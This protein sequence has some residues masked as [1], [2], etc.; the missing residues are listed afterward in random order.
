MQAFF[1]RALATTGVTDLGQSTALKALIKRASLIAASI[2]AVAFD[3]AAQDTH[4]WTYQYGARANLL[5]GA[6]VGSVVDISAAYYNPGALSLVEDISLIATQKVF[7]L[8]SLTFDP[9]VGIDASLSDLRLD[10]AP[11]YFAGIIPF[12]FLGNDVLAYSLF[13]R[14]LFKSDV[15]A[16]A[17]GDLAEVT[18][19]LTGD[20]FKSTGFLRNLN[21][22]WVGVSYSSPF[23]DVMGLGLTAYVSYRSQKGTTGFLFESLNDSGESLMSI[24][25]RGFSYWNAAILFK[26][27]IAFDWLGASVGLTVTT[28]RINLFGEGKVL[29]NRSLF[30][31]EN[32]FVA[33]YQEGLSS[34]YKTPWSVALGAAYKRESTTVHITTEYFAPVS[35]FAV[36]SPEPFIGQST[37]DTIAAQLT[38]ELDDVLNFGLGLE[39]TFR[40][41]LSGYVSFRTD[42]SAAVEGSDETTDM[43]VTNWDIYFITAGAAFRI[44]DADLTAGLAFGWG[45]SKSQ[46]PE[47]PGLPSPSPKVAMKYRTLRLIIAFAI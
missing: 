13:T 38:Q 28:P 15:T 36:L 46:L 32:V 26:G 11:G 45:S 6:V 2:L 14:Y 43:G 30:N 19:S 25:D 34:T 40:P 44:G 23:Q 22:T 9:E 1:S 17:Q 42:F 41:H 21:E 10:L 24:R 39:H 20:F 33:D 4:Y 29:F 18:D 27:G 3:A 5:S 31:S 16:V 37:G 8:S 12:H 47:D 35:E 7:E